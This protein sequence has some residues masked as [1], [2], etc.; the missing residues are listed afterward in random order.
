MNRRATIIAAAALVAIVGITAILVV[1]KDRIAHQSYQ[2]T[3][4]SLEAKLTPGLAEKYASELRYTLDKFWEFYEKGL[5]S[6]NDLNDVME[7]MRSLRA[8]K[9]LTET[10]IFDFLKY[11]STLYTEAMHRRQSE[12][13]PE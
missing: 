13:F 9:K 5:I 1:S 7:K 2:R 12:M 4:R 11:V 8:K 6:Q 3:G 10:E